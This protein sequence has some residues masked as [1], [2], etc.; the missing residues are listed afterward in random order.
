MNIETFSGQF[1]DAIELPEAQ[2]N[3]DTKFKDLDVWDSLCVLNIIAMVDSLYNVS[4]GGNDLQNST[5]VRDIF[6]LVVARVK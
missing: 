2:L 1:A 5:T 6:D 4:V 3:A